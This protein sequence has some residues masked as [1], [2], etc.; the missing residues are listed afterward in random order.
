LNN[1][2]LTLIFQ[3]FNRVNLHSSLQPGLRSS[4]ASV[5]SYYGGRATGNGQATAV[6]PELAC[7]ELIEE[8]EEV[9]AENRRF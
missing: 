2:N 5:A 8:V 7:P 1:Q 6:F 4:P 9:E 3:G